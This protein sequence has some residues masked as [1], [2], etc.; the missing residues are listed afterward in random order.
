M[1]DARIASGFTIC[2]HEEALASQQIVREK[3]HHHHLNCQQ[4]GLRYKGDANDARCACRA[5]VSDRK[6]EHQSDVSAMLGRGVHTVSNRLKADFLTA[7]SSLMASTTKS[8]SARSCTGTHASWKLQSAGD[9]AVI[10]SSGDTQ[11]VADLQAV[12]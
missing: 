7:S 9:A 10:P 5:S 1:L 2:Q 8:A 11:R 6:Q 3:S 12:K 4:S